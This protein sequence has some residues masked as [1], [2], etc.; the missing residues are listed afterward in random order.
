[1]KPG[2]LVGFEQWLS[3]D[4]GRPHVVLKGLVV[5]GCVLEC[6]TEEAADGGLRMS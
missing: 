3:D 1:V 6:V 4:D 5:T 2:D